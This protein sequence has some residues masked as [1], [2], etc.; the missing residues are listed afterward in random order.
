MTLT[1][2]E[3]ASL[4]ISG[5]ISDIELRKQLRRIVV[6]NHPDISGGSF[7][8]DDQKIRF[9]T[10]QNA[11]DAI[12]RERT[13]PKTEL[14]VINA[15]HNSLVEMHKALL[16]VITEQQAVTEVVDKKAALQ[17]LE[18]KASSIA[19]QS[20]RTASAPMRFGS[21]GIASIAVLIAILDKPL[22]GLLEEA[23]KADPVQVR[24]AKLFLGFVAVLG[25]ILGFLAKQKEQRSID[26][27]KEILTDVGVQDFLKHYEDIIFASEN[28]GRVITVERLTTAVGLHV[29]IHDT[30]A[31]QSTAEAMVEKLMQRAVIKPIERR[32]FSPA[33]L[34]DFDFYLRLSNRPP[35][36]PDSFFRWLFRPKTQRY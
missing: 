29:G 4:R 7:N 19:T 28:E 1:P 16:K 17:E 5:D 24:T 27:T 3:R 10:A 35:R 34:I 23:F 32:S 26:R 13:R 14:A 11:L 2:E 36:R 31:L 6:E 22:G 9:E 12:K 15:T 25:L 18:A 8:T 30:A 21:F 20:A 33:F